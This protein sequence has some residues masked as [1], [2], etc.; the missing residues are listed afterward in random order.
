MKGFQVSVSLLT[1]GFR[2]DLRQVAVAGFQIQRSE[3][4]RRAAY[5]PVARGRATTI[6]QNLTPVNSAHMATYVNI[7]IKNGK[8]ISLCV[9][10][11]RIMVAQLFHKN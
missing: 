8:K 4:L 2:R 11:T 1:L 10:Y 3:V 7:N 6:A 9:I 5:V